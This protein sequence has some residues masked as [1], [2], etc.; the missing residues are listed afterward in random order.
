MLI[1]FM[2]VDAY[3]LE[4]RISQSVIM[5]TDFMDVRQAI[6]VHG[7]MEVNEFIAVL[8]HRDFPSTVGN[9][10]GCQEYVDVHLLDVPPS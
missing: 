6:D 1:D 5:E 4:I 10:R 8:D 9:R 2:L 3:S 7:I